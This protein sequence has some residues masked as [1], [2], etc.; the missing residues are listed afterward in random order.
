VV[1]DEATEE[2]SETEDKKDK[3]AAE[4]AGEES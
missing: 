1:P 3:S 4:P 2:K